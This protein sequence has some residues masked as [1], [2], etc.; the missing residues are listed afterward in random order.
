MRQAGVL[1]AAGLIALEQGPGKLS[2][3][4]AN[5]KSWPKA[6]HVSRN[7]IDPAKVHPNILICDVTGTGMDLRSCPRPV[8]GTGRAGEWCWCTI[9]PLRHAPGT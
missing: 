4:H 5:A 1:A 3:D 6:S 9:Y 2:T 8:A 7:Q